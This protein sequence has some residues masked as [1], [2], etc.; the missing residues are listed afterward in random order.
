MPMPE[1]RLQGAREPE[2]HASFL[3]GD[4]FEGG[5]CRETKPTK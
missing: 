3:L 2:T 1:R 4:W 5:T